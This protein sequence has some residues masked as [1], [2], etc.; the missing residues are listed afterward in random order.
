VQIG[1]AGG[2]AE[3]A[4]LACLTRWAR[5]AL[6]GD[7]WARRLPYAHVVAEEGVRCDGRLAGAEGIIGEQEKGEAEL[8][9]R[10][11]GPAGGP[12]ALQQTEVT[13]LG[14]RTLGGR[15]RPEL[16][17][18]GGSEPRM[19]AASV[20]RRAAMVQEALLK[21]CARGVVSYF[22]FFRAPWVRAEN[23]ANQQCHFKSSRWCMEQ[24][25]TDSSRG[26]VPMEPPMPNCS[27]HHQNPNLDFDDTRMI[28]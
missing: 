22:Y 1:R 18:A 28:L 11:A 6:A 5:A 8:Q 27:I 2:G 15:S 26:T 25:G 13:E 19:Q 10:P 7:A 17:D 14:A 16:H 4:W 3:A 24:F 20:L 21:I 23:K 9:H 12:L